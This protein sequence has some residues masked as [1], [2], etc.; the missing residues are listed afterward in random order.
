MADAFFFAS[1]I[2]WWFAEPSNAMVIAIAIATILLFAGRVRAGR[3]ILLAVTVFVASIVLLPVPDLVVSRLEQRF[4]RPE[5]LP[6]HVDGIVL[7]GGAQVPRMTQEYGTP[8]LNE[9]A[10]TVTAF[11]WLA[12]RYPGAK[13]VFAGGSGSLLDRSVSEAETLRLFLVQQG[14][15]PSRVIFEDKSRNTYENAAFAKPLA[16][17][18][19]GETWLLVTQAMHMPRAVGAF[20]SVGWQVV[21]Y[22]EVYRF[23]REIVFEPSFNVK[24][25]IAIFGGGL[26]EW[27]GLVAYWATGRSTALFP[28]P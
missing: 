15:D 7:L 18:Q 12:R 11:L 21:P 1:K 14:F 9:A 28:A 5:P 2:F 13:L 3:I 8:A 27:I 22:P 10:N 17:P 24:H 6:D 16:R 25:A 4:P 20:R 26:R 23:G 19:P